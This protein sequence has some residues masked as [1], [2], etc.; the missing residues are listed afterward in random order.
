MNRDTFMVT[1]DF[2]SYCDQQAAVD[3]LWIDPVHWWQAALHN[4]AGMGWFSSDR[5][6]AEY[7]QEIWQVPVPAAPG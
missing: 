5:T 3:Q 7:A 1:A 6:I 4:V 2:D